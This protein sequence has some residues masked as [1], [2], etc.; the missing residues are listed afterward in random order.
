M[1]PVIQPI[2]KASDTVFVA[3]ATGDKKNDRVS[4]KAALE[5]VKAGGIIQFGYGTYL[6]GKMISITVP[7]V[8]ILGHPNGTTIRGCEPEEMGDRKFASRNCNGLELAG[9]NQTVRGFTFE[10]AY[11]A[12]HLGCCHNERINYEMPD[13]TFTEGS[14][15]YN[16][17]GGHLVEKN[18]FRSSNS[19][20]RTN[21]DWEAPAII[22]NNRFI[23]NWHGISIN[24]NTVHLLDN[25]FS[26]PT[27]E[28]IPAY[29]FPWDAIKIGPPLPLQDVDET[30]LREGSGNIVSNN[31][32]EGYHQ[33]IS[34]AV[35]EPGTSLRKN[36]I[37]D[38]TINIRRAKVLSPE[39]FDLNH[40][41]DSTFVG[42]PIALLNFP[43]ALGYN[44][45]GQES[46]IEN[47][48][49]QNNQISGAEGLGIEI[50]YS[51]NNRILN[52][53]IE[54]I[55]EREPFPGNIMDIRNDAL[56]WSKANGSGIW[57]S[58]GSEDNEIAN[59]TF[60][61]I[62]SAAV[63][64]EGDNNRVEMRNSADSVRDLGKRNRVT[65]KKDSVN[66]LYESKYVETRG[67]RLQYM[68]FGSEGLPV[69]FLQDFHDYFS[70]EEEEPQ[71]A[72]WLARFA[73]D[74]RVL[75]PVRRGWGKSD[76]TGYGYDVATQAEDLLGLMDVLEINRAVL[77]GRI[78]AN[79]DMTWIAE[80]HPERVAGLIYIGN[81]RIFGQII[82]PE[83]IAF[84][85]NYARGVCDADVEE[86]EKWEQRTGARNAWRPHFFSDPEARIDIPA[87]RL[88]NPLWEETNLDLRRLEPERIQEL[89]LSDHCGDK[90]A[91]KYFAELAA[92]E[93]RLKNLRQILEETDSSQKLNETF[94]RAFGSN[95]DTVV[96]EGLSGLDEIYN[97]HFPHM[98]DFLDKIERLENEKE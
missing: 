31:K 83:I 21:G 87:L 51:S 44:A 25:T 37:R 30:Y 10:Y 75:A 59:N 36:L 61:D 16:T 6:V 54:A 56:G 48:L 52:N 27:P 47:N 33:G 7:G 86:A 76:D 73:D 5:D 70:I 32:I 14:A 69:I 60:E 8:K 35:F 63:F 82:D 24:G 41:F 2:D 19:G 17:G 66:Q 4:I 29:G 1:K 49:L 71:H 18:T 64:I 91:Q 15:I 78:P 72:A 50:L 96:E 81:P 95:M 67:I 89:A 88:Y 11:W 77:V 79:Q 12:L 13:G 22:R 34:I 28:E 74:Y 46:F 9:E 80:H 94:E 23:N 55:T 92:D 40:E 20:I 43:K 58:P 68:D 93:E 42:V 97:F 90:Q 26:V 98:R 3:P 45:P 53:N 62:A 84:Q 65:S 85:E 39:N 57:L 38:N